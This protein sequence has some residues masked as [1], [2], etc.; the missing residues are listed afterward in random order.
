M[1]DTPSPQEPNKKRRRRRG[2]RGGKNRGGGV[3]QSATPNTPTNV[4]PVKT[5]S[6]PKQVLGDTFFDMLPAR[7]QAVFDWLVSATG[8]D[9][10]QLTYEMARAA[11]IRERTAYR[12]AFGSGGS[13]SKNIELLT[14]RLPAG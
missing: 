11:V 3:Q 4:P 6:D 7:D 2:K 5:T 9:R 1:T 12:E 14:N 13:S 8:K 10:G